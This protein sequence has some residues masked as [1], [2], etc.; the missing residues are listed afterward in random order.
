[1]TPELL[2]ELGRIN[3]LGITKDGNSFVFSVRKY[4][5]SKNEKIS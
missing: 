4:D 5:I 3:P 1:M 2:W